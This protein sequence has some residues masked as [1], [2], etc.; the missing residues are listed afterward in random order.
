MSRRGRAWPWLAAIVVISAGIRI[1]LGRHV[2][3]PWIM[4][5]RLDGGSTSGGVGFAGAGAGKR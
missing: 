1:A 5:R 4:S 2:I 3:A